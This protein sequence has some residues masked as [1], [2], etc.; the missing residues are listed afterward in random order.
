MIVYAIAFLAGILSL[1]FFKSLEW[2]I[3]LAIMVLFL[4][5]F[6][7]KKLWFVAF[8]LG[9]SWMVF[10][11]Y[12][13]V[14]KLQFFPENKQITLVGYVVSLP[15]RRSKHYTRFDLRTLSHHRLR[16][17]WS[18]APKD[19]SVGEF[20]KIDVKLKRPNSFM[21]KKNFDYERLAFQQ[22]IHGV[23]YVLPKEHYERL[24]SQNWQFFVP[25]IRQTLQHQIEKTLSGRELSGMISGL[26]IGIRSTITP[27]QWQVMQATGTNH[28]M[29][30]SGLHI[31]FISIFLFFTTGW[32]WRCSARLPLWIPAQ[33][34]A[35]IGALFAAIIYSA[36]AGFSLPTQRAVIM[37]AVFLGS[38]LLRKELAPWQ[39][40]SLALF[41]ILAWDPLAALSDS[42]WLS[43]GAVGVILYAMGGRI[44]HG[45]K[46]TSGQWLRVQWAVG[47][48]LAPLTLLFFQQVSL[49]GFLANL[50]A[51][52]WVGFVV[53][54]LCFIY[55]KWAETA[56][57][58]LWSVLEW[59]AA[60]PYMQ[61]HM[62]ISN[63]ALILAIFSV[64]LL[65]APRGTPGRWIGVIG[66]LPLFLWKPAVPKMGELWFKVLDV[67]QG[68]SILI[69]TANHTLIY[70]TGFREDILGPVLRAEGIK[71]ID[72][73]IISHGDKD[74]IGGLKPVLREFTVNVI[75]SSVPKQ[76]LTYQ[77]QVCQG[78]QQW[79]WDGVQFEFLYPPQHYIK[80]RIN[81]D[82]CVLRITYGKHRILLPG[83]IERSGERYLLDHYSPKD[84]KS[85]ILVVPHHGS[86]TS[87]TANFVKTVH[88]K[89]ALFAVGYLNRYRHPHKNV[90]ERYK[91]IGS[92]LYFTSEGGSISFIIKE[93]LEIP[94]PSQYRLDQGY[95][96]NLFTS[97]LP[98][99]NFSLAKNEL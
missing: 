47:L 50:I 2:A 64:L 48:G 88:P 18:G 76:F 65:L 62:P 25:K 11:A 75:S 98:S 10:H 93:N 34:I 85:D 4:G 3:P 1:N 97:Y 39:S 52:P 9:F 69:R 6:F 20:L 45:K 89:Y 23:G 63:S 19:L 33:Q 84:L 29:A 68:L 21:N 22:G 74:H 99:A 24:R 32:L 79:I 8:L 15:E 70:D 81:D 94:R 14:E 77:H 53:L 54:P 58:W 73:L 16:L 59:L 91:S 27:A 90:V 87:S 80:K 26:T 12:Y 60:V 43:F 37:L 55:W 96:W 51:I 95:Y 17:T 28:L 57:S 82:S 92:K 49:I 56:L 72:R 61:I 7:Y 78:G 71:K 83:D 35:A 5:C 40:W 38:I 42:F 67:G 31:G 46:T 41:F 44:S 86:R 36:L 30:I 66:L 13:Y